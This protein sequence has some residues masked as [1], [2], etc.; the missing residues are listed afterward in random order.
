MKASVTER[1]GKMGV[2]SRSDRLIVTLCEI[3]SHLRDT[4]SEPGFSQPSESVE[5]IGNNLSSS[6]FPHM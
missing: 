4:V 6:V 2:L 5:I 3:S 1:G